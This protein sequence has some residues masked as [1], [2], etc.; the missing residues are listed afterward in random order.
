MEAQPLRNQ[1]STLGRRGMRQLEGLCS[2]V[3]QGAPWRLPGTDM[4][5]TE[6]VNSNYA[7]NKNNSNSESPFSAPGSTECLCG[8]DLIIPSKATDRETGD[9]SFSLDIKNKQVGRKGGGFRGQQT[10]LGWRLGCRSQQPQTE[11]KQGILALKRC[12]P[13]WP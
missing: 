13:S 3:G 5:P 2:E 9:H 1:E 8:Y 11:K 4:A 6:T 10:A 7:F 12:F